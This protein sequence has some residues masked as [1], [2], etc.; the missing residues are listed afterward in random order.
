MCMHTCELDVCSQLG[1]MYLTNSYHFTINNYRTVH[2]TGLW[3]V[4]TH[5]PLPV[6]FQLPQH[7][8]PK[9]VVL[10]RKSN[11]TG[12]FPCNSCVGNVVVVAFPHYLLGVADMKSGQNERP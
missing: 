4:Y 2:V 9:T 7:S 6:L 5:Y 10:V 1:A 11:A 3:S 8:G 12:L